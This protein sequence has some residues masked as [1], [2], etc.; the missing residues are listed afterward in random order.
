DGQ[1]LKLSK[2]AGTIVSLRELI[3]LVGV[4]PLRYTLIR[5]PVDSP[6]TLDVAEMTRKSNENPVYYVQ[7]V[8]ARTSSILRNAD[9]LDIAHGLDAFDPSLLVHERE[10]DLLRALAEYPRVVERA[11][12]LQEPHRVARYLEDTASTFHRFYDACRVLP[13]G[14]EDVSPLHRARLVLVD[15]TRQV[16]ANGL[17][18]LGVS[19]PERM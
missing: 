12:E 15:A 10:G 3:D 6:L 18:L 5:Y 1:E 7:Y 16:V 19:A 11:A 14:D 17:G 4:D 13:Q 8:H 9:D 2:R